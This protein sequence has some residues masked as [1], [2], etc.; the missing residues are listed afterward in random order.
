MTEETP[1]DRAHAAMEAAPETGFNAD[2]S[3]RTTVT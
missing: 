1:L 3:C 2:V